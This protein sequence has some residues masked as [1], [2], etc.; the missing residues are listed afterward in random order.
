MEWIEER[1]TLSNRRQKY[2][3]FNILKSAAERWRGEKLTTIQIEVS[4]CNKMRI[5]QHV[6]K[7]IKMVHREE[8]I[9]DV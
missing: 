4:E 1:M 8:K 6:Y 9:D 7:L 3:L 5:I 2:N